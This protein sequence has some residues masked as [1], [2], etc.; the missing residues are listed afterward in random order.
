MASFTFP[1]PASPGQ[2]ITND[3]TGVTYKYYPDD[4]G[5]HIVSSAASDAL[6]SELGEIREQIEEAN[7]QIDSAL[8]ERTLL[9]QQATAKNDSQD[10]LISANNSRD[11]EQDIAINEIDG[12]L[13]VISANVGLLQFK[14][15]YTYV[16]EKTE[17]ACNEAY[18]ECLL[19]AAGDPTA[20]SNCT[21]LWDTCKLAIGSELDDGTFTSVGTLVQRETE[22]FVITND[23]NDGHSFDWDNL[24]S[25][26]DYIELVEQTAGDTILY[27]VVA[28][29]IRS[30]GE[31][32]IRVKFIRESGQGDGEF[33]FREEYN[34][35]VF[36]KDTGLD[37]GDADLRYV[38][39]PYTV[40]Y[41]DTPPTTGNDPDGLLQTGELWYDTSSLEL[42][43]YLN[44]AWV[45]TAKPPSQDV[46]ISEALAQINRIDGDIFA[47]SNELNTVAADNADR[48]NIYY[49][50]DVPTPTGPDG[51]TSTVKDGDIWLDSD[52]LN[53][54]FYS[55]GSWVNPD[56][57]TDSNNDNMPIGSIIFWGGTVAKIPN[58]WV[59]CKGQEAP[60]SVKELTGLTNIPNLYN[61]M[62][63]GAGGVFGPSVGRYHSSKTKKH[64]HSVSRLEPG[65]TTG[66][67][68]D[69]KDSNTSAYRYW[70]G[71]KSSNGS[72]GSYNSVESSETGDD[73]TAPPVYTGIY[74]MKVA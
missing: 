25:D 34:I 50:D 66:W 55:Q 23:T 70:R 44:N 53:L 30:G 62:P 73:I 17:A 60:S 52:D 13:D 63:A 67:P 51:V 20:N 22:E 72:E 12:R 35:R 45:C 27:Q 19:E 15:A 71:N 57:T 4:G 7:E 8:E 14:G 37:L 74:I 56:R 9:L 2:T 10:A 65:N 11:L 54:K 18:A 36:K 59:E 69:S 29:P 24:L 58:G 28:E 41:S 31:E 42:F 39:R 32:R 43:V 6:L 48:K 26:G 46:V 61:Y 64:S 47:I 21:R 16:I 68:K 5:W 1:D 40:L 38:K 3:E 49:S 33:N